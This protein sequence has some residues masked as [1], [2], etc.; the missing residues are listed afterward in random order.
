MESAAQNLHSLYLELGDLKGDFRNYNLYRFIL[1]RLQGKSI[2]DIG[3]G[4]GHFLSLASK[5]GYQ[6]S[7]LEDSKDLIELSRKIYRKDLGIKQGR[8]ENLN[9]EKKN[10]DAIV[11]IDVLEHIDNDEEALNLIHNKLTSDG[12]LIILVPAYQFLFGQRDK[13]IGHF[14]RYS[15]NEL[16]SKLSNAHFE[17]VESRYW[18]MLGVLP[19]FIAEKIMKK[20]F[21]VGFR[22]NKKKGIVSNMLNKALFVWFQRVENPINLGFGLSVMAVAKK[23]NS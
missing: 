13:G 6:T 11:M 1:K 20:E 16:V 18:N 17:I 8:V 3:C 2:L 12:R 23:Q 19:Y 14:R 22:G 21:I 10:F 15:K 7:G 5:N 4:A 9:S